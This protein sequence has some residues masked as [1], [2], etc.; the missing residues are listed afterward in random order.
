MRYVVWRSEIFNQVEAKGMDRFI[1]SFAMPWP[2]DSIGRAGVFFPTW[3]W[4]GEVLL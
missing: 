3:V 1:V 2:Y 4:G